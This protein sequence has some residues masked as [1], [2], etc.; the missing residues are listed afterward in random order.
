MGFS[1]NMHGTPQLTNWYAADGYFKDRKKPRT[2]R[3]NENERPLRD[4]RSKHL[5]LVSSFT[6][7]V[8][9]YDLC[10]YQT[11]LIRYYKPSEN[12]EQA[13]HLQN[14]W[15]ISSR[16]F[17]DWHSWWHGKLLPHDGDDYFKLPISHEYGWANHFWGDN[18]TVRLVLDAR[19]VVLRDRSAYVPVFRRSSSATMRARRKALKLKAQMI[20]DMVEMQYDDIIDSVI[21]DPNTYRF[22]SNGMAKDRGVARDA[23]YAMLEDRPVP[24]D[25]MTKLVHHISEQAKLI[26][27]GTVCKRA[28]TALQYTY[29]TRKECEGKFVPDAGIFAQP[30][31]LRDKIL[32]TQE[33]LR[34]SLTN[35]L[36]DL[37]RLGSDER[38]P[39]PLFLKD[40]PNSLWASAVAA[41]G[42]DEVQI[43]EYL[44]TDTY[45]KLVGRKG[46]IY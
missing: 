26:A 23:M 34:K 12:G 9:H 46:K 27:T 39:Y 43:Q 17:L 33:D 14:H 28:Q 25:D 37:V 42:L 10:L 16:L 22:N 30:P 6:N 32:I 24:P 36:I 35:Y 31:E 1:I 20:L 40:L 21:V 8:Q 44:G 45:Y 5:A 41:K 4:T 3:W 38:K 18:F 19:S 15:S 7:G 13:V 11:P 29:W 2:S